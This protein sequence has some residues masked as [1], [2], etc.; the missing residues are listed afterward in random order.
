MR[1]SCSPQ[2]FERQHEDQPPKPVRVLTGPGLFP[3]TSRG[4]FT[5]DGDR[6]AVAGVVELTSRDPDASAVLECRRQGTADQD[7]DGRPHFVGDEVDGA[8]VA[9]VRVPSGAGPHE[10]A[11]VSS[12]HDLAEDP[13]PALQLERGKGSADRLRRTVL[14]VW[15]RLRR[16]VP[17]ACGP[18]FY[19]EA[20]GGSVAALPRSSLPG[21]V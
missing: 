10:V 5:S 19:R 13:L 6:S 1:S 21:C 4:R 18:F 8:R 20:F 16:P 7:P 9:I 3:P 2:R 14:T 15:S 11:H 17:W 12:E